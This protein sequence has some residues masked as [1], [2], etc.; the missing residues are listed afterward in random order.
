MDMR[1]RESDPLIIRQARRDEWQDAMALAW[2]TFLKFEAA[3]Y[4][5]E[6]VKNFQD[7]VTDSTLYRMF[8]V[9]S[10]EMFLA[11]YGS[12]IVGLLSL[13]NISHISLLF[14]DE[15]YHRRGIATK[16]L[17]HVCDY[18][19]SEAGKYSLTVNAAPYGLVFYKKMG[20][21]SLGV[22][23]TESGIRYTPMELEF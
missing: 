23:R 16:L 2:R 12:K 14:V 1:Y 20:F 17:E 10:Y 4:T 15:A 5:P 6:G 8:I 22:E 13:R 19:K 11:V 18:L 21:K 3:D 9:G 7:F